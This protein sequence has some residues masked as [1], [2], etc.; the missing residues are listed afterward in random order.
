M[1]SVVLAVIPWL[2]V[3]GLTVGAEVGLFN[4]AYWRTAGADALSGRTV[5]LSKATLGEGLERVDATRLRVTDGAK[6][7]ID[8]PVR[9]DG[10]AGDVTTL[11]ITPGKPGT[12]T[13]AATGAASSAGSASGNVMSESESSTQESSQ[14]HMKRLK[15]MRK[16]MKEAA[17]A[18]TDGAGAAASQSGTA[19]TV[20][21]TT[22]PSDATSTSSASASASALTADAY[23]DTAANAAK[24]AATVSVQTRVATKTADV[25]GSTDATDATDSTGATADDQ[26]LQN[27]D[28]RG[29]WRDISYSGDVY[30]TSWGVPKR[31]FTITGAQATQYVRFEQRHTRTVRLTIL[32]ADGTAAAPGTIVNLKSVTTNVRVPMSVNPVRM[33]IVFAILGFI[34]ALRPGSWLYRVPLRRMRAHPA[35]FVAVVA[36]LVVAQSAI[37]IAVCMTSWNGGAYTG[38]FFKSGLQHWVN[39]DQY[40]LLADALLHGRLWLDLPVDPKLAAMNNPYD[41]NARRLLAEKGANIFWDYA[42]HD[43]RYYSY[44][45]VLPALLLF[46]P[47]KLVTGADLATPVAVMAL[48]VAFIALASALLLAVMRRYFDDTMSVGFAFLLLTGFLVGSNMMYSARVPSLYTVPILMSMTLTCAALLCW[49]SARRPLPPGDGSSAGAGRTSA[50]LDPP[51]PPTA[52]FRALPRSARH[53]QHA[54]RVPVAS[55]ATAASTVST[56]SRRGRTSSDRRAQRVVTA[57]RLSVWRIA[58]GSLLMAGN[59]ASRPQFLVACLIAFPIFWDEIAHTRQLFSLRGW[60]A[61][62]WAFLP[63]VPVA[64][65]MGWYDAARFGSPFDLGATYNLT[66]YDMNAIRP[67]AGLIPVM[68]F[69]EWLQPVNIGT[70]FPFVTVVETW[71]TAPTEPSLGGILMQAPLAVAVLL[72]WWCREPLRRRGVWGT[73]LML[74]ACALVVSLVDVMMAGTNNRYSSDAAWALMLAVVLIAGCVEA[75]MIER[76]RRHDDMVLDNEGARTARFTRSSIHMVHTAVLIAVVCSMFVCYFGLFATGRLSPWSETNPDLFYTVRT[77]FDWF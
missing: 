55:A 1:L 15:A 31:T 7:T 29:P 62:L 16:A 60:A 46:A 73:T 22:D 35:L 38:E 13:S 50:A 52:S 11:R 70:T 19:G 57:G 66:G 27:D 54:R 61:T 68:L 41:F 18:Q 48:G 8:I 49:V 65:L 39:R 36:A 17:A 28:K 74:S 34:W 24:I 20:S 72:V 45:G 77:W 59:L 37:F 9:A 21:D 25:A 71:I 12:A 5:S 53:A 69:V 76:L 23:T 30:R 40:P 51:A 64:L 32:N 26:T 58:L 75:G 2:L 42:F 63:F 4:A 47:Y 14:A 56:A 6:A 3:V 10:K 67:S 44:F 33:L 43:G